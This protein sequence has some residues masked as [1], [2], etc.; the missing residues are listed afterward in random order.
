MSMLRNAPC[1]YSPPRP[2]VPQ[3]RL[4]R[5]WSSEHLLAALPKSVKRIAVMDRTKEHGSGGERLGRQGA[6]RPTEQA[7]Q[8]EVLLPWGECRLVSR[9]AQSARPPCWPA[10]LCC[11]PAGEPLLL[12]VATSL[13]RKRR[14]VDVIVGGRYGLASKDFTP[15][16]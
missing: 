9:A 6:R 8:G 16:M 4:F 11:R 7:Q 13:Q 12:D 15:A 1:R 2:P 10:V 3:V 5:P 14:H